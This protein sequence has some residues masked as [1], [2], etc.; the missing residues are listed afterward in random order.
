M[1]KKLALSSVAM[2]GLATTT[3]AHADPVGPVFVIAM[4]N[5]NWTQSPSLNGSINQI[6]GDPA[7]PFINSLVTPG[8]PNAQYVSYASNYQNVPPQTA[9]SPSGAGTVHPSEPNYIWAEA[10]QTAPNG[11][12]TDSDPSAANKNILPTSVPSLS[13]TLQANGISW[14]SYQEDIDLTTVGGKLTN[15]VKP[16]SQWTS[17]TTS[18]SG[19]SSTYTN[20]YNGSNQYNYA[21]K[22]NPMA[23]FAATN[24]ASSAKNYAPMQQLQTD[25]AN[26]TVGRYNWITPDQYNDMHTALTNGFT[27]NGVHYTGDQA[28]IAQ[29]D[30]FL[31]IVV[32]QIE[33]SKAFQ[34]Q[35]GTII[36]WNDETEGGDGSGN[37]MMEI[38][39]SKDAKG[40]AY[41]NSILYTHSS[42]LLTMCEL[43]LPGQSCMG[44]ASAPGVNDLSDLFK[45]GSIAAAAPEPSTWAMMILGFLG[46]GFVAT[47][48]KAKTAPCLAR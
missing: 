2:L 36:I 41:T 28:S 24:G 26:N 11:V 4:E 23:F 13:A 27:Y 35:N 6:L 29:G 46:L 10:G 25:L 43:M 44:A 12:R 37:T 34:Q 38:V 31:S 20:P 8:N 47:R 48:R 18:I 32:P 39:I 16:Q 5:H 17:P 3:A 42:D 30:N 1:F 33:A 14:K 21:V 15:T 22:H 19:T 9:G 7:A 45:A 40:N